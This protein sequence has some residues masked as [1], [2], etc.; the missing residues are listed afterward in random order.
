[1]TEHWQS[2]FPQLTTDAAGNIDNDVITLLDAA[3][4]VVIPAATTVFHQGDQCGNYIMVVSGAVKVFTRAENGREIVLYRLSSGDT[5]VLTTSCLFGNVNYPAEGATESE[6]EALL[7]PAE[8]FHHA[9]QQSR[10]FREFVFSSFSE[11]LGSMISLVEEVA[12]GKMDTRLARYLLEH[13]DSEQ[14]LHVT[15]QQLATEL[16]TAREVISRLLKD[17]EQQ[18]WLK[19]HRGS[20]ELSDRPALRQLTD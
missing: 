5:C 16:G 7:I 18:G 14:C 17:F 4:P 2:I 15:H 10:S 6:V 20:V 11:H 9:L 8:K 12:F 13:C 1:M 19:L 3:K